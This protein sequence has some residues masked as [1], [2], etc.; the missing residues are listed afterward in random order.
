MR[1]PIVLAALQAP[2]LLN[3]LA[4]SD[5]WDLRVVKLPNT[6]FKEET[7]LTVPWW[8]GNPNT[9]SAFM[10]CDITHM[11][12]ATRFMPDVPQ[13]V[14]IHSGLPEQTGELAEGRFCVGFSQANLRALAQVYKPAG[15]HLLS[16]SY[17]ELD[18]WDRLT[19]GWK[20]VEHQAWTMFSRPQHRAPELVAAFDR[21]RSMVLQAFP[22]GHSLF[23]EG[24]PGG[25]ITPEERT[26]IMSLC[27]CYLSFIRPWAGFG[28][29]EH[30]C[31]AAGVPVLGRWWGDLRLECPDHPGL[32]DND[33]D[34][35]AM[36]R[37]AMLNEAYADHVA[38]VGLRY[39]RKYRTLDR[40]NE[41]VRGLLEV[42]GA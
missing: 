21:L 4:Q 37:E 42:L 5:A 26:A 17:K 8:D 2:T 30:E 40:L 1:R 18:Q 13:L 7:L 25:F 32:A 27:S 9:V 33:D 23:G 11:E 29:A 35:A 34:L 12:W 22:D 6:S 24:Q 15:M 36:V 38:E 3:N 31:M 20:W 41:S 14:L 39:I 28:L 19:H 16:P 10:G